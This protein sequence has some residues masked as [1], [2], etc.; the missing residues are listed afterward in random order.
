MRRG[1]GQQ[2]RPARPCFSPAAPM[3]SRARPSARDS[4]RPK[5]DD[6]LEIRTIKMLAVDK[7][8]NADIIVFREAEGD[9]ERRAAPF[10]LS[11]RLPF[12]ERT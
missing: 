2:R 12:E 11:P 5:I 10:D 8:P 7:E 6:I 3:P 9:A 4:G 1:E